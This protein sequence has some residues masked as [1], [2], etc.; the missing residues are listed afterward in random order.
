MGEA[1]LVRAVAEGDVL[2]HDDGR[3][4]GAR[5]EEVELLDAVLDDLLG[6]A[7]GDHLA[8]RLLLA[9]RLAR[10][11]GRAVAEARDVLLHVRHLPRRFC[12]LTVIWAQYFLL[13]VFHF[14]TPTD[15]LG[16][17]DVPDVRTYRTYVPQRT[18]RISHIVIRY[19][20]FR[21]ST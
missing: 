3:R 11:L 18:G 10:Q 14:T 4:D 16:P 20:I 2:D 7:R 13:Q 6:E 8:Q 12:C 19:R 9:L 15:S 1:H 21:C 17:Q 5:V